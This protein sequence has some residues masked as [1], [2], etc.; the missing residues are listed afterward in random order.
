MDKLAALVALIALGGVAWVAF[1]QESEGSSDDVSQQMEQIR[2][3]QASLSEKL[4]RLL[5]ARQP[6]LM[7]GSGG[8]MAPI[9][10]APGL[11]PGAPTAVAE[12]APTAIDTRVADLEVRL[13]KQDEEM[14]A[15]KKKGVRSFSPFGKKRFFRSADD[16]AR[17]WS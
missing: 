7:S 5:A 12:G 14:A 4:D 13:R 9:D 10:G 3:E 15:L 6:E 2:A 17:P 11:E 16:A 1:G 8:G